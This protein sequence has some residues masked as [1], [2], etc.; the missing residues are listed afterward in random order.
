VENAR[1]F[2]LKDVEIV[3]E[4]PSPERWQSALVV[5]NVHDLTLDVVSAK[6]AS[7]S[8]N[9]ASEPASAVVLKGVDNAVVRNCQAQEG[10]STFLCVTGAG[11][12]DV[13]LWHND[14]RAATAPLQVSAEV[15]RD[16]VHQE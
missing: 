8:A 2:R 9:G 3:W 5:E 4:T 6:Q 11:T 16:A 14:T 15:D 7:N 13:M 10:T 12:R 1:H